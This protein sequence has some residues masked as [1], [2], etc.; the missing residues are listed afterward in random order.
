M[1]TPTHEK[2]RIGVPFRKAAE[3]AAGKEKSQKIEYYYRA[4]AAAGA[5][6]VPISLHLPGEEWKRLAA[7]IDGFVL[8]G[9]PADV[10]PAKYG[11]RRHSKT[12]GA[13]A[14]RERTDYALLDHAF[15]AGKPVL[16][17]C[18]GVQLL[19][20]YLGGGLIQDIPSAMPHALE[21][22]EDKEHHVYPHHAVRIDTR[23]RLVLLAGGTQAEVN[24]SHH[25]SIDRPGRNLAVTA[26]APDG[27][28][29]AVEWTGG[30]Q[31]VMGVQWHPE[32]MAGDNLA[33][34]IFRELVVACRPAGMRRS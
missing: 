10:D 27:V 26:H 5:E 8:P 24:S 17:I 12:A 15:A 22:S 23:S 13:D 29:E 2:P 30:S 31:W 14:P 4:V 11:A 32:R 16:A 20:V 28:I 3:E 1:S 18:Y 25:Q 33:A 19:N 21:H 34:A 7:T 9:S 6:A